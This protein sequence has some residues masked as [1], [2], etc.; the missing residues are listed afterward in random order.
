MPSRRKL[1]LASLII[2]GIGIG[3]GSIQR[4]ITPTASVVSDPRACA[5][6]QANAY[7][8]GRDASYPAPPDSQPNS[9]VCPPTSVAAYPLPQNGS[10]QGIASPGVAP[11][12]PVPDAHESLPPLIFVRQNNL[13]LSDGQG[14]PPVQL[15]HTDGINT[16]AGAPIFSPDG[17]QVAFT[18]SQPPKPDAP[19][20]L[21]RM[22]LY[23]MNVDG[24]DQRLV[25]DP[26]HAFLWRPTW[27]AHGQSIYV[28]AQEWAKGKESSIVHVVRV[29]LA[30]GGVE[31]LISEAVSV[32]ASRDGR[33]LA[34]VRRIDG[35]KTELAFA[36]PAGQAARVIIASDRFQEIYAP[37]FAPNSTQILFTAVGGPAV[38]PQGHLIAAT[39]RSSLD[40]FTA[41][42]AP[43]VAQA[44]GE[45][46]DLWIVNLDGTGLRR[47][48]WL[49]ADSPIV[50]Y[51]P[52]GTEIIINSGTGIYRMRADGSGL[53]RID[54]DSDHTGGGI[55]WGPPR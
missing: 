24:S 25:W 39:P 45:A 50:A 16:S 54:P 55:D 1:I 38:D 17:R 6:P 12:V 3:Y 29:D 42:F 13:W 19:I 8:A 5:T 44:H 28:A 36:D 10:G 26:D 20:A 7:P 4:F 9:V 32:T 47:L 30:S 27:A 49:F 43:T 33:W 31:P 51:S 34:F 21:S 2:V 18:L 35:Y 40:A 22:S 53:R 15:T 37:R 14:T 23:V 46:Y 41:W 48:T 11:L 52:D